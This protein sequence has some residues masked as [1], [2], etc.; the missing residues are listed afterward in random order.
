MYISDYAM[1]QSCFTRAHAQTTQCYS[2]FRTVTRN[3]L[4]GVRQTDKPSIDEYCR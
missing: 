1:T 3:L 4:V 2:T